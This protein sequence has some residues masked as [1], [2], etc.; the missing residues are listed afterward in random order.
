M[1]PSEKQ[2]LKT[3]VQHLA[4]T[5][6][7]DKNSFVFCEVT[8]V[9]ELAQVCDCVPI[10]GDATTIIPAVKLAAEQ[11]D[12]LFFVPAIGS[13][14]CV[15]YSVKSE[16]FVALFSDLDKGYLTTATLTQF[17]DGAFG[18]LVKVIELTAK[19]NALE[20]TL[21]ALIATFNTHVHTGVR[22]GAGSSAITP[23]P[24]TTNI[25]PVTKQADI[26]NTKVKHGN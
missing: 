2:R 21:N 7:W 5:H 16:P 25:N 19:I 11:S 17:N 26:E 13:T 1:T 8:S 6:L 14:I 22:I 23:T 12:G 9:D 10:G 4:G 24:Q 15:F 20:N 18:G 3:A